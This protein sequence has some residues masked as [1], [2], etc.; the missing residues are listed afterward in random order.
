MHIT[1]E[2]TR[3]ELRL[4]AGRTDT[5]PGQR[6]V[7]DDR[8]A[9]SLL[10]PCAYEPAA[11]RRIRRL[12]RDVEP[13]ADD[14]MSDG[15]VLASVARWVGG[16]RM[17]MCVAHEPERFTQLTTAPSEDEMEPLIVEPEV[18]LSR[19]A[20]QVLEQHSG[21]PVADIALSITLPDGSVQQHVT[22]ADGLVDIRDI[23]EGV[24]DV[25][26]ERSGQHRGQCVV[27]SG[28]GYFV[29]SNLRSTV[30]WQR[31]VLDQLVP[32]DQLPTEDDGLAL[33]E[34]V[35]HRVVAGDTLD[36]I[37][38]EHGVSVDDITQFNWDTTD[39][40]E[41]QRQLGTEVGCSRR[42]PD[43]GEFAFGDDDEPGI[44]MV[45][46]PF[47]RTS[48]ATDNRHILKVKRIETRAPWVFSM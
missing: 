12:L 15:Q 25:R 34:V 14:Q 17:T 33:V 48:K 31:E 22:D 21:E 42:D 45:P 44:V 13:H 46:L 19:V 43:T 35:E 30:G 38:Q 8:E 6:Q 2:S 7:A 5:G 10:S 39:P 27:F 9:R 3:H 40:D 36:S 32:I 4:V 28:F 29:P 16:G 37:A 23:P 11:M 47:E 26:S 1:V 41:I 24:C 20:F 18:E